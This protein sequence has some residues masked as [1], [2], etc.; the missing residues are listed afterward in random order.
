MKEKCKWINGVRIPCSGWEHVK[1]ADI[2]LTGVV[3]AEIPAID[4]MTAEKIHTT[5]IDYC[6]ACGEP[7]REQPPERFTKSYIKHDD[8]Q[9]SLENAHD[10][11]DYILRRLER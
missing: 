2:C 9:E 1:K 4:R 6:F 10:R 8:I 5:V 3:L 11:I 7:L